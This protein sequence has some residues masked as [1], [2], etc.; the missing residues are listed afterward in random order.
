MR[1]VRPS[2]AF[3]L[4]AQVAVLAGLSA[5]A[6]LGPIGWATG[7]GCGL[8][9]NALFARG[10]DHAG[11]TYLGPANLVTLL[12]AALVGGVAGLV[13][14][15][16][17]L[18]SATGA[19]VVLAAVALSLDAVDGPVARRTG[20][21]SRLGARFDMEVDAFLIFILCI[22]VAREFGGFVLAIGVAR[23]AYVAAGWVLAWLRAPAPPRYWCKVVAAIQGIV[24]TV[25]AA[26][27]LP[28][29]TALAAIALALVLLAESFGREAW[30][31]W[32]HRPAVDAR[33]RHLADAVTHG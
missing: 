8:V 18:T 30:W 23:Y 22:F 11:L 4:I 7:L 28:H 19:L 25:A 10:L 31:L 29:W 21:V 5:F 1:T 3:G 12:R 6:G 9:A 14:E 27:V 26:E 2:L 15:S 13:A 20:T 17:E 24:L 16:F 33:P 32:R